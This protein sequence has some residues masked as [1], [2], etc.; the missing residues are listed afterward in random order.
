MVHSYGED[1][2]F[3]AKR[4]VA[5][6]LAQTGVQKKHSFRNRS[7]AMEVYIWRAADVEMML[8][9]R[10]VIVACLNHRKD[11]KKLC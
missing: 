6:P 5:L 4:S 1:R 11:A 10:K 9:F 3:G 2:G 8:L 7:E